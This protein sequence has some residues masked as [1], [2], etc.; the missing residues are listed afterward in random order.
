MKKVFISL[1]AYVLTA[2]LIC[3]GISIFATDKPILL[4]SQNASYIFLQGMLYF[5]R[6]LPALF[7]SAFLML[8]SIYFG[9]NTGNA[10]E[11]FSPAIFKHF[12][13]VIFTSLGM[14]FI[15]TMSFEI[16]VPAI[17]AHQRLAE[18][19]P[20]L[21]NEYL[22]SGRY[23]YVIKNYYL[24]HEYGRQ[25]L[26]LSP[27]NEDAQKLI[28]DSERSLHSMRARPKA[29]EK[30]VD[31]S[32]RWQ[33][34][35]NETVFSLL[36][37]SKKAYAEKRWFDAHY[38]AQLAVSTGTEADVNLLDARRMA[39]EAWNRL[40]DSAPIADQAAKKLFE[41]K[42]KAYFY[43]MNDDNLEAYYEF[44]ELYNEGGIFVDPDIK[45]YYEIA[46]ERLAQE[47]FFIDETLHLQLFESA[48]NVYFTIT[49]PDGVKDVVYIKGITMV[50][51]SGR[52]IQYLREFS[53]YTFGRDGHFIR[54]VKTPYAK[55]VAEPISIFD[56][57]TAIQYGIKESFKNIPYVIL[58]SVA[59]ESTRLRND[60]VFTY[61]KSIPLDEREEE[62]VLLLAMPFTDFNLACDAVVGPKNMNL[63]NLIKMVNRAEHFGYSAEVFQ[64]VLIQRVTYP[65]LLLILMIAF[66]SFAWNYRLKHNQI[67]KFVW[68]L[69]FPACTLVLYLVLEICIYV[70]EILCY[71]LVGFSSQ[72]TVLSAI[73]IYIVLF[74]LVSLF[75][76]ARRSGK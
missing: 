12:K 58:R 47:A 50:S 64:A 28:D 7:G 74:L 18:A 67:F 34:L 20:R 8:L 40:N 59:R 61:A 19:A 69:N 29:R 65:L 53:L 45:N 4:E 57:N 33:E 36:E 46:K 27:G 75:F 37:K 72:M 55:M 66:A 23:C 13:M 62:N 11:R 38:F 25:A 56:A 54:S 52:M 16:F 48:Q 14:V 32:Y 6:V 49:H 2:F 63:V 26:R 51:N 71:T 22:I 70:S 21:L 68:I 10:K 31:D 44:Q 3:M 24:A 39:A 35:N 73:G 76:L 43:L 42:K 15:L 30:T 17:N 5:F 9:Q 1:F 41:K 60:P